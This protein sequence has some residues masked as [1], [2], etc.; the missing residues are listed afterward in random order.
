[1]TTSM[2]TKATNGHRA[3][4]HWLTMPPLASRGAQPG[5]RPRTLLKAHN[6]KPPQGR[7]FFEFGAIDILSSALMKVKR[8]FL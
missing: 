5:L 8:D 7:L 4:F 3:C 6:T 2:S 1:M